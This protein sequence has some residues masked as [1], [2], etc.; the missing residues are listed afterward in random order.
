MWNNIQ[1]FIFEIKV[2]Y[3]VREENKWSQIVAKQQM[4]KMEIFTNNPSNGTFFP[5]NLKC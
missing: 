3:V 4:L 2:S 1:E 5:V